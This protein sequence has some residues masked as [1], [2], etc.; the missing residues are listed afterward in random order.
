[1]SVAPTLLL[2]P[3]ASAATGPAAASDAYAFARSFTATASFWLVAVREAV[4]AITTIPK[5]SGQRMCDR[6]I[7]RPQK[8]NRSPNW[9]A[10]GSPTAVIW[11]NVATGFVG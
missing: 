9:K 4:V 2:A 11:L 1:M 3:H 5:T 7:A 10:R 6:F 8:V